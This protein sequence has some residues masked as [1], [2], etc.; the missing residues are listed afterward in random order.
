[1]PNTRGKFIVFDGS[2]CSGKQTQAAL[3]QAHLQTNG[4]D[5]RVLSFPQYKNTFH[6]RILDEVRHDKSSNF[7]K[8]DP[9]TAS[10]L[11]IGDRWESRS[12]IISLLEDGCVVIADRFTSANM[13][14]Q[15]GKF[16]DPTERDK[17]FKWLLNLE[18]GCLDFP[19]PDA[20]IF[21]K[22]PVKISLELLQKRG[23]MDE[24]EKDVSYL[25]K[26]LR[27]AEAIAKEYGWHTIDCAPDGELRSRESI[28]EEVLSILEPVIF[29]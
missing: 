21:F 19:K 20:T 8:L 25:I 28:H 29:G 24:A 17:Y 2:E 4:T 5:A 12:Q 22:V 26:S 14:H 27:C 11:F 15:G 7:F 6:G 10:F 1:M 13:I 18:F 3:L 9:Y 23:G 16:S